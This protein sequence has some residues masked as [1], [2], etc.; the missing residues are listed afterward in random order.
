[1]SYTRTKETVLQA[2]AELGDPKHLFALHSLRAGGASA[3]A[4]AGVSDLL[5]K[6]HGRWKTDQAKDGIFTLSVEKFA[7]LD[8][9]VLFLYFRSGRQ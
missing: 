4:N 1:M 2:F 3:A 7:Y 6:R 5:F 8:F 9:F